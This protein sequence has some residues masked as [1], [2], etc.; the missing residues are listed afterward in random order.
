MRS[1][2]H[3]VSLCDTL[4]V[5]FLFNVNLYVFVC[6]YST[7]N[8]FIGILRFP[9]YIYP[10]TSYAKWISSDI[11]LIPSSSLSLYTSL[12]LSLALSLS[13]SLF[14]SLSLSLSFYLTVFIALS[15]SLS[16]KSAHEF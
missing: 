9:I 15:W 5:F 12:S 8:V 11:F 16:T 13:L 6:F 14:L 4:C 10:I 2:A 1:L 7:I 3:L